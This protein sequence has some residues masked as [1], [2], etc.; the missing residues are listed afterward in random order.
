MNQDW[1]RTYASTMAMVSVVLG[2]FGVAI[3]L[4]ALQRSPPT[5]AGVGSLEPPIGSIDVNI[6]RV[7]YDDSQVLVSVR[8]P[9]EWHELREFVQPD[10]P[11]VARI[12]S[13]ITCGE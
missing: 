6:P 7:H 12:V 9:G 4:L 10:N 8:N 13:G 5:T 11:E 3:S 2:A 1:D